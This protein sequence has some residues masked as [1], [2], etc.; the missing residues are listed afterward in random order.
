MFKMFFKL[1]TNFIYD[2]FYAENSELSIP[3]RIFHIAISISGI[4]GSIILCKKG[5]LHKNIRNILIGYFA[6]EVDSR[7]FEC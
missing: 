2:H 6:I 7:I 5:M 4:I 3:K 1:I